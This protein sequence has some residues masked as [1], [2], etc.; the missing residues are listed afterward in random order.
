MQEAETRTIKI[1]AVDDDIDDDTVLRFIEFVY[2]GDYTSPQK[3]GARPCARTYTARS[4]LTRNPSEISI[5][6]EPEK[7]NLDGDD[8]VFGGK[9]VRR[10]KKGWTEES[11][12][13][14]QPTH[15]THKSPHFL[16]NDSKMTR[17]KMWT[18]FRDSAP[19]RKM[20]DWIP[21]SDND[22][23]EEYSH[24]FLCH[25]KLYKFSDRYDCP[26]LRELSLQ[27][28]WLTLSRWTFHQERACDVVALV[29]YC[30]QHTVSSEKKRDALRV[31][32]LN[33]A[34]C[35]VRQLMKEPG[36][37]KLVRQTGN[38]VDDADF[39]S[40]LSTDL[41]ENTMDLID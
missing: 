6:K 10:R 35:Y 14:S 24:V 1:E 4:L 36:F 27:K 41:L 39:C 13:E 32:V 20:D 5:H 17:L 16:P 31:L 2:T 40:D 30:Y 38:N 8:W 18:T 11:E 19:L 25:A 33:Y 28:L 9:K 15:D 23:H 37:Q 29:R 34:T 3:N 7:A 22:Q 12:S 26:E 21:S